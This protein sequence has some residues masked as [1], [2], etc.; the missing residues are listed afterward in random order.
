MAT[1]VLD[2]RRTV[3]V[4]DGNLRLAVL[5][6]ELLEDE[7][8]LRVLGTCADAPGAVAL[9]QQ[10]RP[11]LVLVAEALGATSGT[12]LCRVLRLLS[13]DAVLVLRCSTAG[14][15]SPAPVLADAVVAGDA[16]F[17]RLARALHDAQARAGRDV[18]T[19]AL[20]PGEPARAAPV[21]QPARSAG[22]GSAAGSA[23][24]AQR[25]RLACSDC[26][27]DLCLEVAEMAAAVG[28]A[29]AFFL[30][31]GEC[32]TSLD[33]LDEQQRGSSLRRR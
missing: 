30:T 11:D 19:T 8:D 5:L 6:A 13:P 23:Q 24:P 9:V 1:R 12:A 3:V 21:A 27:V 14:P 4:V 31:H 28:Q 7:C 29:R 26:G 33:L 17:R 22:V 10:H 32:R 20:P 16:T 15:R 25:L 18:V 2:R